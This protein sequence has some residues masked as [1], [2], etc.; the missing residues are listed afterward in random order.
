VSLDGIEEVDKV[1]SDSWNDFDFFGGMICK[2]G[3]INGMCV[4]HQSDIENKEK[5]I[6]YAKSSVK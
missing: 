5:I 3:C 4:L 6:S 1:F 2:G